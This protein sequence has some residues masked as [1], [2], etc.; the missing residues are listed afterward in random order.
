MS[1][2]ISDRIKKTKSELTA[3]RVREVLDYEPE[4]GILRWRV[5]RKGVMAGKVAGC[6]HPNG[7]VVVTVEFHLCQAHRLAWLYMY[8]EWPVNDIDHINGVKDDN[9]IANLR[10]V[11]HQVNKQNMRKALRP[12]VP[13]P[14]NTGLL[15]TYFNRKWRRFI[16]QIQDPVTMKNK[17]LGGYAT[18]EEAHAVYLEAKRRLHEGNTL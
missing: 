3:E 11:S 17:Y 6:K 13:S 5:A 18:A 12:A 8:G 16:A 14:F 10:D 1:T 15:G 2:T 4:T 9:R 7:Y